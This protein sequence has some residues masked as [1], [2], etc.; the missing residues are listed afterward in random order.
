[1]TRLETGRMILRGWRDGDKPAF[2]ELNAD[3]EVM[4]F[5]P[6]LL[7][8]EQ[9]DALADRLEALHRAH[10]ITFYAVEEKAT[11]AFIGFTGLLPVP[12]QLPFAPAIEIGWRLAR[13]A[14]GRGLATEAA[15]ASLHHGFR[16]R[17]YDEIVAYAVA[18]NHRSR[19]VMDRIG[20]RHDPSGDFD[21]PRVPETSPHRRHVLYR[22]RR[23]DWE[24]A[25][26][27]EPAAIRSSPAG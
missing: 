27:G 1:M 9:S 25:R 14:W 13:G 7:T 11:A 6:A 4:E 17:G 22:L 2:A 18:T 3:P 20:L 26:H 16:D 5:F 23:E 8:R 19:R 12:P 10:G 24:Q 15:E 21:H